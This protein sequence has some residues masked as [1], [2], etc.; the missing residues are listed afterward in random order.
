MTKATDQDSGL[1]A[2]GSGLRAQ[3]SGLRAQL[4]FTSWVKS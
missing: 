1:R 3:G 2:Q 4:D